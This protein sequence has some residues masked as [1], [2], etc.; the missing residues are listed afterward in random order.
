MRFTCNVF[1]QG[2][3]YK[4]LNIGSTPLHNSASL[5]FTF[6]FVFWYVITYGALTG[7]VLTNNV[8]NSTNPLG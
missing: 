5:F 4:V 6:I 1:L 7:K 8:F 3:A 2:V